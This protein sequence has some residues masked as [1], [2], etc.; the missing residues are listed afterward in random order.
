MDSCSDRT[1]MQH[2]SPLKSAPGVGASASTELL[3][4]EA[5]QLQSSPLTS[6]SVALSHK[7]K[8]EVN[9]TQSQ[10]QLSRVP[11]TSEAA[12]GPEKYLASRSRFGVGRMMSRVGSLSGTLLPAALTSQQASMQRRQGHHGKTGASNAAIASS[13]STSGGIGIA[14]GSTKQLNMASMKIVQKIKERR[15]SRMTDAVK[16]PFGGNFMLNPRGGKRLTWDMVV[17][18]PLL[19]YLTVMMPFRLCFDNEPKVFSGKAM[20]DD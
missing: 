12:A 18:A 7:D 16:E 1:I 15:Q 6:S 8:T 17:T 14:V 20:T 4:E 13:G 9:N 11:P 5:P 19:I 2:P 3:A 10:S